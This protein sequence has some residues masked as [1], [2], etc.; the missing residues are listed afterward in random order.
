MNNLEDENN[1]DFLKEYHQFEDEYAE[2]V[3]TSVGKKGGRK[4][5][6]TRKIRKKK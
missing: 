5:N 6:K 4:N 1:E 2:M 3:M